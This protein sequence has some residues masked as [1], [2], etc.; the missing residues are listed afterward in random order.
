MRVVIPL[1]AA[2]GHL[3]C[4]S[5]PVLTG[6]PGLCMSLEANSRKET[7]PLPTTDARFFSALKPAAQFAVR[8]ETTLGEQLPAPC[9]HGGARRVSGPALRTAP[10]LTD[11]W[12][13]NHTR[14]RPAARHSQLY[15]PITTRAPPLRH[16]QRWIG[17]GGEG[18]GS[19]RGWL[20]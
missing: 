7:S 18:R 5:S 15:R 10:A 19:R 9:L 12:S 16:A 8:V 14:A 4:L 17:S 2:P 3:N 13:P 20:V 1:Q 11:P 6:T